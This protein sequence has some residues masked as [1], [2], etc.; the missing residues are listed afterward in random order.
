MISS[1][2]ILLVMMHRMDAPMIANLKQQQQQQ[3]QPQQQQH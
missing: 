2:S 3:Q 1:T